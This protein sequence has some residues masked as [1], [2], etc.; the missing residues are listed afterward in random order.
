MRSGI[1]GHP[2]FPGFYGCGG[3]IKLFLE[4]NW[5]FYRLA[6]EKSMKKGS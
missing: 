4:R 2:I 1:P 6:D 5:K 3:K